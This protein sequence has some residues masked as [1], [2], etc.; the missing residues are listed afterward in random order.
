LD[1]LYRGARPDRAWLACKIGTRRL[2]YAAPGLNPVV[3]MCGL[4]GSAHRALWDG[5]LRRMRPEQIQ[6]MEMGWVETVRMRAEKISRLVE[7]NHTF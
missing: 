6:S 4:S 1:G 7:A 5:K 3:A 2:W